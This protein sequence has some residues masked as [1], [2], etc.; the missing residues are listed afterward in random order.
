M[1]NPRRIQR[2]L[3][4]ALAAGAL[5]AAAA[6]PLAF[7]TEAGAA[8]APTLTSAYVQGTAITASAGTFSLAGSV[9]STSA[10]LSTATADTATVPAGSLVVGTDIPAGDYIV[11]TANAAV[12]HAG[13]AVT[14]AA[15]PTTGFTTG[16]TVTIFN[17]AAVP[18][19]GEGYLG[20]AQNFF[21]AGSGFADIGGTVT[22]S[23]GD[24]DLAFSNVAETSSALGSATLNATAGTTSGSESLTLTDPN[25]ASN[26]LAGAFTVNPDPTF[27][28]IATNSIADSQNLAT[29]V[30]TGTGIDASTSDSVTFTNSTNGTTLESSVVGTPSSTSITAD[31]TALNSFNGLAASPGNYTVTITNADGGSVTSASAVFTVTA[32]GISNVSPSEVANAAATPTITINGAGFEPGA[33]VALS[34]GSCDVAA[35]GGGVLAGVI[36]ADTVVNSPAS[37]TAT[38]ST[39]GTG[40]GLCTVT[41][42]NPGSPG[43]GAV[44]TATG[45]LGIGV[46][47]NSAATITAVAISPT[48]AITPGSTATTP[49]T[50][51]ITGT[52]FG[53]GSTVSVLEGTSSTVDPDATVTGL[54]ANSTGTTLTGSLNVVTGATAGIDGV[55][56]TNGTGNSGPFEA[57]FTVTGPAIVSAS[58]TS[59]AAGAPIGTVIT[60]TGTGLNGSAIA[61]V[62]GLSGVFADT[63]ATTATFQL[64]SAA[65]VGPVTFAV[66]ETTSNGASV[67]A[68]VFKYT[69]A[70]AP[71][72]SSFQNTLNK[73]DT[74]GAGAVAVPVVITGANFSAGATIGSFV[75][76]YGVA[77]P[78]VTAT[79]T[80]V[81]AAGTAIDA[82]LTIAATDVNLSDG[83][84]ITDTNGGVVK[85]AGFVA[86]ES[87]FIDAAP[88]ITSVTPATGAASATSAFTIAGT[89]F[90]TGAVVTLTPANGTC[91]VTTVVS[92]TELTVSCTLGVPAVT[93]TSL[94]VTN[95]DGGSATSAAVLAAAA[96]VAPTFHVNSAHGHGVAGRTVTMTIS[97]TGF[98]GQPKVTSTA[99]G[100]KIGVTGDSGTLL[101]LRVWTK[102]GVSGTHT[103][104]VTLANGKSG[105][106]N[107]SIVK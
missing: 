92:S 79:V 68:P 73:G 64:T 8:T 85:V 46:T 55:S 44:F 29:D 63:S 42:T 54:T 105:K 77:D 91:G 17:P 94:V 25:G 38:I 31:I 51:T 57:A 30:I 65:T 74:V 107:Y 101:T 87:I 4:K 69:V 28:A 14:L 82:T 53:S 36:T 56:V 22:L 89:G 2:H 48:G 11:S 50:I 12:T 80:S 67:K 88:A 62:T 84:T 34:G 103:F 7:A 18:S 20:E 21:F 35:N 99:A 58:P 97:G 106:A 45:V 23:S 27:T 33:A 13:V 41:V 104:T 26:A 32:A 72:V 24:P 43:N 19:F 59:I 5:L 16:A 102:A 61:T 98:Y 78:G 6:L 37:I 95:P 83:Y 93:A 60:L 70:P 15:A 39:S 100:S 52:G 9:G 47:G 3:V 40:T 66:S 71:T 81:N 10:T 75:N 49:V 86:N 1:N 76:T 90:Q 96:P